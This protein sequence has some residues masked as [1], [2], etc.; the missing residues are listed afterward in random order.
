MGEGGRTEVRQ[1]AVASSGA[2]DA[3]RAR[4]VARRK[5]LG[6]QEPLPLEP[7]LAR[8]ESRAPS[9]DVARVLRRVCAARGCARRS[10]RRPSDPRD[11]GRL[12]A[13]RSCTSSSH[14]SSVTRGS[15]GAARSRRADAHRAAGIGRGR[16]RGD[17]GAP[18][19]GRT[20]RRAERAVFALRR[21][22]LVT[23]R[24]RDS[25]T[26]SRSKG[27]SR[28]RSSTSATGRRRCIAVRG[29]RRGADLAVARRRS[30]AL[31][32]VP[33]WPVAFVLRLLATR[34]VPA[35]VEIA[36]TSRRR[37][38]RA[39]RPASRGAPDAGGPSGGL[40]CSIRSGSSPGTAPRARR[41]ATGGARRRDAGP[42]L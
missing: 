40:S 24:P 2:D 28:T 1:T 4:P 26:S 42:S 14:A 11:A 21:R 32:S 20:R 12:V 7:E 10:H 25:S 37:C 13:R 19:A 18:G 27:W 41:R 15:Q 23:T 39:T 8:R 3:R 38:S 33:L 9:R 6:V 17:P 34:R 31:V 29:A 36:P 35:D 16:E 5:D 30:L 22:W